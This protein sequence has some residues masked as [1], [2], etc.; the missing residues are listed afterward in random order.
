MLRAM[1]SSPLSRIVGL[2]PAGARVTLDHAQASQLIAELGARIEATGAALATQHRRDAARSSTPLA[3]AVA[4]LAEYDRMLEEL[5]VEDRLLRSQA[6]GAGAHVTVSISMAHELVRACAVRAV[7]ELGELLPAYPG[8]GAAVRVASAL[9]A[10]WAETLAE[11]LVVDG[12][13]VPDFVR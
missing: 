4:D 12:E 3:D 1:T 8:D 13:G 6:V 9:V 10:A 7:K 2:V 5:A 11:L